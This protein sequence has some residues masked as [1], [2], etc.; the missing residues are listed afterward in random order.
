VAV[1]VAPLGDACFGE[2][3]QY[4]AGFSKFFMRKPLVER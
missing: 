1:I 3:P 4:P 2:L